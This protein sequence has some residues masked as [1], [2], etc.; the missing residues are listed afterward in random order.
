MGV[1]ALLNLC[2]LSAPDTW[3]DVTLADF[4]H[5][6][7]GG[8]C[9]GN[10]PIKCSASTVS[11]SLAIKINPKKDEGTL[12]DAAGL[13]W[14]ALGVVPTVYCLGNQQAPGLEVRAPYEAHS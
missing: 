11:G 3:S 8:G 12:V 10:V 13:A 4:S 5:E 2:K 7:I 14:G 1:Q 9:S 6:E